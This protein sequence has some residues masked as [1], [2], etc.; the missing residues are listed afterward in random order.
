MLN[1]RLKK[2]AEI[3]EPIKLL[4]RRGIAY[5]H[6]QEYELAKKDFN[7]VLELDNS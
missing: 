5:M 7:R 1:A 3:A 2:A 4:Y 6:T